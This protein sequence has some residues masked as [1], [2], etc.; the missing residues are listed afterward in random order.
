MTTEESKEGKSPFP[1][2]AHSLA[3]SLAWLRLRDCTDPEEFS[4]M[5]L[6]S[7]CTDLEGVTKT[8]LDIENLNTINKIK[9]DLI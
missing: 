4:K 7:Y 2:V 8:T 5:L 9:E 1:T 3:T 6:D